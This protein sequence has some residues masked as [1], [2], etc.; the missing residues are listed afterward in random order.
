MNGNVQEYTQADIR[1]IAKQYNEQAENEKHYAPIVVGHPATNAPAYGWIKKLHVKGGDLYAEPERVNPEFKKLVNS[2]AYR[3][4]SAA[5]YADGKLRHVGFLGACPPAIKG[6]EDFAFAEGEDFAVYT[7]ER[8]QN[9]KNRASARILRRIKTLLAKIPDV[10]AE[11]IESAVPDYEIDQIGDEMKIEELKKENERLRSEN[12]AYSEKVKTLEERMETLEQ[13]QKEAFFAEFKEKLVGKM[14]QVDQDK[15]MAIA[16]R[17]YNDGGVDGVKDFVDVV[18][19]MPVSIPQEKD[20]AT[21]GIGKEYSEYDEYEEY[22]EVDED[23]KKLNAKA[24]KIA[25]EKN[26]PYPQAL[27]IAMK[28]SK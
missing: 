8:L 11:S 12:V 25:K 19:K 9:G 2:G 14:P 16:E 6:L 10:T 13:K 21:D 4:R 15:T 18:D 20:I 3:T 26:L 28:E 27:E 1:R 22:A 23:R 5:F 17:L 7:M 24:K